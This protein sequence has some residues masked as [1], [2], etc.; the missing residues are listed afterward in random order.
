MISG[1]H[2]IIYSQQAE[3]LREFFRDELK[4]ASVDAGHGWLIFALPP[5]EIAMHP[6][7]KSHHE[8]FLMCDDVNATTE[9]L[10]RKGV[11]LSMPIADRGWGL[12]TRL[13]L[14]SGDEIG[15][16]QPKHPTAIALKRRS[17]NKSAARRLQRSRKSIQRKRS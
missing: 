8:L 6:D 13:K 15:L 12:V 17:R 1:V 10:K 7:D 3:R 16:Y 4:F 11:E 2:A 5:A 14:P 9:Q